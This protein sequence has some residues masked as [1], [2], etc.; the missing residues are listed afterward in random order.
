MV[1]VVE[2]K[3]TSFKVKKLACYGRDVATERA[4]PHQPH[5][6]DHKRAKLNHDV[7]AAPPEQYS[8]RITLRGAFRGLESASQ[9][10]R[11]TLVLHVLLTL[12]T[13]SA[14]PYYRASPSI[15]AD[16]YPRPALGRTA[17]ELPLF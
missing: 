8:P 11:P 5:D 14:R 1:S 3:C 17:A 13:K 7:I 16:E 15:S 2:L 4:Q 9:L 6:S 10:S 12:H